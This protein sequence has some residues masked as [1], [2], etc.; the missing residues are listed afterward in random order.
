MQFKKKYSRGLQNISP[1]PTH[2]LM[3]K[4]FKNRTCYSYFC[5]Q[6]EQRPENCRKTRISWRHNLLTHAP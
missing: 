6:N 1:L 2:T 5:S 3:R 4:N